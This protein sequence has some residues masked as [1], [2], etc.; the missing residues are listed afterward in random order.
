MAHARAERAQAVSGGSKMAE[1][2]VFGLLLRMSLPLMLSMMIQ[3]LYNIVDSVFIGMLPERAEALQA[4]GYAYPIQMLLVAGGVG[5]GIGVNALLSRS[6]GEKDGKKAAAAAGNGY[7]LMLC[8]YFAFLVFGFFVLF[9]GAYF[10]LC[11]Q[12]ARIRELGQTYLGICLVFSFGQFILLIAERQLCAVGRTGLAMTMQLAGAL[13]NIALDPL[14]IFAFDMG[15]AGAA[16]AT[17]L[18]Q[19]V[20]MALGIF[21]NLRFNREIRMTKKDLRPDAKVIG[22]IFR[23]GLPAIVLQCLQSLTTLIMQLV[24]GFLWEGDVKDLLVG[25]YGI[26]YKLQYFVLMLGY[27]LTNASLSLLAY[28]FGKR[29]RERV[30]KTILSTLAIAAVVAVAG[31]LLFELLPAQL[32]SLFNASSAPAAGGISELSVGVTV[33]RVTALSFPFALLNIMLASALQGLGS[34]VRSMIVAL[35]RLLVVLMPACFLFGKSGGIDALWWG[36]LVAEAAALVYASFATVAVYRRTM[37]ESSAAP[38]SPA[39]TDA[40][41]PPGTEGAHD[42][43]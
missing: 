8:F 41:T 33:M 9:R 10:D 29:D 6:L 38:D 36:A 35:L 40:G 22:E 18:G 23:I 3:A 13:T 34:G 14:F 19:C 31:T 7:F 26:F 16:V 12:N 28:N 37:R 39:G 42:P 2:P 1:A 24:F 11:T 32:L 20:S 25:I 21:L 15:V 30:K 17:V 27:G 43:F 4:L 5:T